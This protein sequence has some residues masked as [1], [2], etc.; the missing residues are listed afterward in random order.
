MG[1]MIDTKEAVVRTKRTPSYLTRLF[2]RGFFTTAHK[3]GRDWF[4]DEDELA[5]IH[6][7]RM[8]RPPKAPKN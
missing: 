7:I 2:R 3:V 1:K 4:V 6:E 5:R 8:G